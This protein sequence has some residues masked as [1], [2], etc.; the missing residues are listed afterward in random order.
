MNGTVKVLA[1][2]DDINLIDDT[3]TTEKNRLLL[4]VSVFR[5]VVIRMKN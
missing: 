2:A 1:Y 4:N 5:Q 3:R